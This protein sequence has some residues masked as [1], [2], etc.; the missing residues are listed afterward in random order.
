VTDLIREEEWASLMRAALAG[1]AIAYRQF[2]LS[3]T[4]HLRAIAHFYQRSL[5]AGEGGVEDV[6][7]EVLLAVHLKSGTWDTSRPIVPWLATIVRNKLI[8]TLRPRERHTA[9]KR[10]P[11]PNRTGSQQ[12]P[13]AINLC[14]DGYEP[15]SARSASSAKSANNC[16]KSGDW[17]M[18]RPWSLNALTVATAPPARTPAG[19]G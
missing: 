7:Q 2:L 19:R 15:R 14:G 12:K 6:V 10:R 9:R 18:N 3:V 11:T 4:S 13:S 16:R 1:D 5:G 8:D 17:S